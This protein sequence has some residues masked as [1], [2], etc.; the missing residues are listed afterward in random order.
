MLKLNDSTLQIQ[1][2]PTNQKGEDVNYYRDTLLPMMREGKWEEIQQY[3]VIQLPQKCIKFSSD[4]WDLRLLDKENPTVLLF[5]FN[6]KVL[7]NRLRNEVKA[8]VLAKMF[9][10]R[11]TITLGSIRAWLDYLKALMIEMPKLGLESFSQLTDE[12]LKDIVELNPNAFNSPS[13]AC[14]VN[15]LI[16]YY[17]ALPFHIHFSH[18]T[19]KKLGVESKKQEQHLAI[20]PRIYTALLTHF[21]KEVNDLMPHLEQ[22]QNEISRMFDI[23]AKFKSY[24]LQQFR[25]GNIL[26]PFNDKATL[27][28]IKAKFEQEECCLIDDLEEE[29]HSPGR[30]MQIIDEMKPNLHSFSS[31]PKNATWSYEP[32][33]VGERR[34]N[35][36]GGFKK[37]LNESDTKSKA[38]CLLLSG[39]RIDE[40][41]SMHPIYGAQSYTYNGQTIFLFT[42]RQSKI[43]QGQQTEEDIFVTN[44][45]GHNA[46]RLLT[47]IHHPYLNQICDDDKVSYFASIRTDS[48]LKTVAKSQWAKSLSRKVNKWIEDNVGNLIS[49]E[50]ESFLR[51][52]NPSNTGIEAGATFKFT[53]HQTRRSFAFYMIGLELMAYPQLKKQLS[54]LSSAMTRHYANNA[55]YWGALRTEIQQER[56]YQKSQLLTNV[57]ERLAKGGNIAGGKGKTL[58]K[59]AG[60]KN[61]FES[62]HGDRRLNPDYWAKLIKDGKEHIHAIAPGM[63]CT[64]AQCDMRINVAMD[65]C[66]D[67]E[68]DFIMDG[69]YAEGKRLAAHRNLAVLDEMN[70]L[71]HNVA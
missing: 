58:K 3:N 55:S 2:S 48:Y 38:L 7:P 62:G 27:D 5:T 70:D 6:G 31:Y 1:P 20:P 29:K 53:N 34:F 9:T 44:Q 12:K 13:K 67:C 28:K 24:L 49:T 60:S 36:I 51:I 63:Y 37:F 65:E 39:M 68:F 46:F 42:T 22:I 4:K 10:G 61:Y 30:W 35:T 54:H 41:N 64:N 15:A 19:T 32:F 8:V 69:L 26:N 11:K 66:V 18:Q 33:Q 57:Y 17:E 50:D 47:T 59:L 23:K 40:L 43:T 56:V 16:E 52:S 14:A 45:T 71:N 25:C 21:S